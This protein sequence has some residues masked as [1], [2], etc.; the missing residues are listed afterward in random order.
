MW[1]HKYEYKWKQKLK[2]KY[3]YKCLI[4]VSITIHGL[5][6]SDSGSYDCALNLKSHVLNVVHNLQIEGEMKYAAI[7]SQQ[8]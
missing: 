6:V 7:I 5:K 8:Y 2:Y 3:K 4:K 1:A